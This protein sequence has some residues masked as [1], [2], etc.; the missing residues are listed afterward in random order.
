MDFKP[1]PSKSVR[2]RSIDTN[3]N[4][5][6]ASQL[7]AQITGG[8]DNNSPDPV[9]PIAEESDDAA[10]DVRDPPMLTPHT[11]TSTAAP[12]TLPVDSNQ[13]ETPQ[14]AQLDAPFSGLGDALSR[15]IQTHVPLIRGAAPSRKRLMRTPKVV[16]PTGAAL[17]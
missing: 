7:P 2:F 4:R 17:R 13:A 14:G 3:P 6:A 1:R 11:P 12:T 10:P 16:V 5:F 8:G 9:A 15:L